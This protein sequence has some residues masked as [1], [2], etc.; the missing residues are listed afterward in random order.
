M[1]VPFLAVDD[2]KVASRIAN[3]CG[4][5]LSRGLAIL[6]YAKIGAQEQCGG[7]GGGV[8]IGTACSIVGKFFIKKADS[9]TFYSRGLSAL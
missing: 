1:Y 5:G 9:H 6:L 8:Q 2:K 3:P 7:G 4:Y